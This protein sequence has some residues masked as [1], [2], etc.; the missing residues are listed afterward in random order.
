MVITINGQ[1]IEARVIQ[2]IATL[3]EWNASTILPRKG[4]FM[5]VGDDSGT[6]IN[7]KVGNGV[8]MFPA[9]PYMFDSIQQNANYYP[10]SGL[11]LPTP[12]ANN[13][14]SLVGEGTYTFGGST[15]FTVA[16]GDLAIVF[17]NSTAWAV[18]DSITLPTQEGTDV[19]N[20]VGEQ[21]PKEKAVADYVKNNTVIPSEIGV[22]TVISGTNL[23]ADYTPATL[24]DGILWERGYYNKNTGIKIQTAQAGAT[25][26][27]KM[28]ISVKGGVNYNYRFRLYGA[29]GVVFLNKDGV[30]KQNI[31]SESAT[32]V[33]LTGNITLDDDVVY[34]GISFSG[35]TATTFN[36]IFS[37]NEN[38]NILTDEVLVLRN[39]SGY[40]FVSDI[41]NN[42]LSER[43]VE[44]TPVG[45]NVIQELTDSDLTDS[46]LWGVGFFRANGTILADALWRYSVK[47][48]KLKKGVYSYKLFYG[49][50]AH[51]PIYDLNQNLIRTLS[52]ASASEVN[53]SLNIEEDS[54]IRISFRGTDFPERLPTIFID[55]ATP[56][57]SK[58]VTD[59]NYKE[60]IG[61]SN[62]SIRKVYL[63]TYSAK[64]R[65]PVVTFICDDGGKSDLE[66]YLPLLG[67]YGVKSTLA[68]SKHWVEG[69]ENGTY[70]NRLNRAE[71]IQCHKDGHD[72][73]NH[74]VTHLYLN[75]ITL[76][77]ADKE[78]R[79][80]KLYLED[81]ISDSVPMFVSPFGVRNPNIDFIVSKYHEAN[82]ITGYSIRNLLPLD[83]FFINRVSF[84]T[85][86]NNTLLWESD[87]LP[88]LNSCLE[89]NEWLVF[90]VHSTYSTYNTGNPVWLER[91]NELRLIIEFCM[92]NDIQI[93]T[94]K[95][96]YSYWKNHVD[97]GVRSYSGSN[98]YQLAMDMSEFNPDYFS[99]S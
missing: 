38:Y 97:I 19:L 82:F 47:Y 98:C 17:W 42:N 60:I 43:G 54:L 37:P 14:F 69:Q 28:L 12:T 67:E 66:W 27:S 11:A 70:T 58:I 73:A 30:L 39:Q 36:L 81:L 49:G 59:Q 88:A 46:S 6:P 92:A 7:I 52:N 33:I 16:E 34:M 76:A 95:R 1:D 3:A 84:D 94:A 51:I 50:N 25:Y 57:K 21:I 2:K 4:E 99:N 40:K 26:A 86:T 55:N 96:A 10:I 8:D 74:T 56:L 89:N 62:T 65:R 18:Q 80:N 32:A 24:E 41:S 45:V 48:Y 90:A 68:I 93:M 72:I 20:P 87:L 85:Q 35:S 53:G 78:I 29:A 61:D 22:N 71:V 9:L 13:V 79:D 77:E 5:I 75:Q 83:S 15:A 23:I 91:R 31:S 64:T 44:D 63:D